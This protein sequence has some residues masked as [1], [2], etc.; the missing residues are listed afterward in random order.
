VPGDDRGTVDPQALRLDVAAGS[1]KWRLGDQ[2]CL[3]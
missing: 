2:V 1:S 3:R